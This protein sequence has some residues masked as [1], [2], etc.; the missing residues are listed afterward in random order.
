MSENQTK[1]IDIID[2]VAGKIRETVIES[3]GPAHVDYDPIKELR[4]QINLKIAES[5]GEM[6]FREA[7]VNTPDAAN[8]LRDGIRFYAFTS[9]RELP[10][11]WTG[12]CRVETSNRPQE[13]YLLDASVGLLPAVRSG[14]PTPT[15]I[16]GFD[17]GVTVK[18]Y[19]YAGMAEVTGDDIRFDRLGKIR[20]IAAEL[21]RAARMT[22]TQQVYNVLTT[23]TNYVRNSTTGD[24]DIGANTAATTF[25]G[26][27]LELAFATISTAK[28]RKSGQYLGLRPDTIVCAPRLE[29]PVKQ[30]LLSAEVQRASANNAAEVRGT[31]TENLYRG[32][33]TKIIVTPWI[34]TTWQWALLDSTV[35][36]MVFQRVEPLTVMEEAQGVTSEA[37]LTRDVIRYKAMTYFGVAIIDDRA[38][39]Y[40]SSS[41]TAAVS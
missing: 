19:M 20:Q 39:Y 31:G 40:S 17:K 4:K 41:T 16:S 15:V 12:F 36:P 30:L 3:R 21:G 25:S 38:M 2:P 5:G 27:G 22:E 10:Q 29:I 6:D 26:A 11:E 24:N 32:M 7:F 9:Y 35:A 18:N 14:E 33:I 28:D 37:Y 34:G 8:L 1:V 23:T 13:E